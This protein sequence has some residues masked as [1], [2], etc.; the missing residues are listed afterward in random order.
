M[1]TRELI[2]VGGPN[3][4]GKTTFAL[5]E[6][7]HNGGIYLGADAIAAELAPQDPASAAIEA[8]RIFLQR[9]SAYLSSDG[10]IVVE[11]TLAGK[12]LARYL[13]RA[14]AAGFTITVVFVFLDSADENVARVRER[15]K[16]GGH[17]VPEAD[18]RRRFS[19]SF[20]NFWH[21][22][23]ALA[24]EWYVVYNQFNQPEVI[25]FGNLADT[26]VVNVDPYI[27]LRLIIDRASP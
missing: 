16:K 19:R 21:L 14:K 20:H 10:R 5:E 24:H 9:L 15:V 23:R 17:D 12:S 22:Y 3:G 18:I 27:Q 4:A 8:G 25:A 1:P 13:E 7:A 2:L 26:T 11:S 6:V